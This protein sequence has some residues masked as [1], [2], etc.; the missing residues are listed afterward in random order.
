MEKKNFQETKREIGK[1]KYV[2]KK[3]KEKTENKQ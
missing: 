3:P 1:G 2:D